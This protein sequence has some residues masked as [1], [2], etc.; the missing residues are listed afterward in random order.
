MKDLNNPTARVISIIGCLANERHLPRSGTEIIEELGLKRTTAFRILSQL[1][2]LGWV[3][4]DP[5]TRKYQLA[6]RAEL[7]AFRIVSHAELQSVSLPYLYTLSK[8]SGETVLLS[9]RVGFERAVIQQVEGTHDTRAIFKKEELRS[10]WFGCFGTSMLSFMTEAEI[11]SLINEAFSESPTRATPTGQIVTPN[12]LRSELAGIRR[13]GFAV[14]FGARAPDVGAVAA[15]VFGTRGRVIGSV[16]ICGPAYRFTPNRAF[17]YGPLVRDIG[18]K[19]SAQMG[20]VA[21]SGETEKD[22]PAP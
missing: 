2:K 7:V 20:Y 1:T 19:I 21:E 15:P 11:E 5:E 9:E 10:I 17:G 13:Q 18:I 22:A 14:S 8:A 12:V 3:T 4:R 6:N 16:G